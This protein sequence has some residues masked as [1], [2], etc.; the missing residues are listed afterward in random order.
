MCDPAKQGATQVSPGKRLDEKAVV[1]H[2]K[3]V[4]A[5]KPDQVSRSGGAQT[6]TDVVRDGGQDS[7][8]A[9]TLPE[10]KLW[11]GEGFAVDQVVQETPIDQTLEGPAE[12]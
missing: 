10:F 6:I 4:A 2:V 9:S 5:L 8:E 12:D 11:Q 3:R 7:F 1:K